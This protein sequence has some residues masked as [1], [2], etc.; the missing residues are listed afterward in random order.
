MQ[1]T[2]NDELPHSICEACIHKVNAC[3]DT[4]DSFRVAQ[5]RLKTVFTVE[6]DTGTRQVPAGIRNV[7]VP[8]NA[9]KCS[10]V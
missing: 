7:W 6:S 9:R 1:I 8:A 5:E 4:L 10:N 2:P 3:V